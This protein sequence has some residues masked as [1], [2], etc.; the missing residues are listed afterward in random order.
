L[1]VGGVFKLGDLADQGSNFE[2]YPVKVTVRQRNPQHRKPSTNVSP[3]DRGHTKTRTQ[4]L[5]ITL[6]TG[7]AMFYICSGE[8]QSSNI[9]PCL[10]GC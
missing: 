2:L 1:R 8:A 4:W 9:N 10:L 3:E 7:R 5:D 6:V